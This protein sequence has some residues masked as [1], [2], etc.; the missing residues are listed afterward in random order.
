[1][2][3]N[4]KSLPINYLR[5]AESSLDRIRNDNR[6][7]NQ[8]GWGIAMGLLTGIVGNFYVTLL[9]DYWLKDASGEIK[10]ILI[11]ILGFLIILA[12]LLT[13]K[14]DRK[15][16][17]LDKEIGQELNKVRLE[18]EEIENRLPET[19]SQNSSPLERNQN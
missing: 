16:K 18:I 17:R 9:Y 10:F 14:D 5:F 8:F 2:N 19:Q 3:I 4:Y 11:E 6:S 15:F 7:S 12:L 13:K 1:M